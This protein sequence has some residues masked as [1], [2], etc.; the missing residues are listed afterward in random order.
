[1]KQYEPDP[2]YINFFLKEYVSSINKILDGIFEEANNDFGLFISEEISQKNFEKKSRIKNDEKVSKFLDWYNVQHKKE[3]AKSSSNLIKR[4]IQ[5]NQKKEMPR[6]KIMIKAKQRFLNDIF[7]EIKVGQSNGK[8]IS[9]DDLKLEIKKQIPGFLERLNTKRKE[10]REPIAKKNQIV[11]NT[12]LEFEG[13]DFE[14]IYLSE[15]Y[16]QTIK[17][18]VNDS[19]NKI[20]E[21]KFGQEII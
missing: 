15:I 10:N 21:L 20:K 1:M 14:I 5:L 19:R 11:A 18:I 17:R 7:Q 6:I 13:K 3:D 16:L 2:H 9:K 12:F 4:M 8:L